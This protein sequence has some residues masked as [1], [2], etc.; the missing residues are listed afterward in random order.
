MVGVSQHHNVIAVN[1]CMALRRHLRGRPGQVF[2][3]EVGLRVAK[4]NAY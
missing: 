4:A 1:A 2:V 3:G